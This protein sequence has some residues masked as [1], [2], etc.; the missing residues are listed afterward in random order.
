MPLTQL[1]NAAIALLP[2]HRAKA[3]E[4]ILAYGKADLLCYR[5]ETPEELVQRQAAQWDPLLDWA[6]A[7]FG[8]RLAVGKGIAYVEQPAEALL[9]LE[10][11]VWRHDS[12][13]L[14]GLHTAATISGSLVLALALAKVR[15]DAGEALAV[16]LLDETWQAEKWG[17]DTASMARHTRLRTELEATE[18]FLRL[19]AA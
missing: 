5:A 9:A 15:L 17:L 13:G 1:A 7:T 18:R 12:F 6:D 19:L 10:K 4:R 2:E 14:V 11:A 3:A 8:A 16:A